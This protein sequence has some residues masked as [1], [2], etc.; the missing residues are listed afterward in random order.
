MKTLCVVM[1]NVCNLRCVM[2]GSQ[3]I[4]DPKPS[5]FISESIWKDL[6]AKLP[7]DYAVEINSVGEHTLHPRFVEF[8]EMLLDRGT[9]V[10]L[11][12]NGM[13]RWDEATTV[14]LIN[15]LSKTHEHC[16]SEIHFSIDGATKK[17]VQEIRLG[18]NF[19]R[20][21]ANI[22]RSIQVSAGRVK[23]GVSYCVNT[24]N[25][26]EM[27]TLLESL[28]GLDC[29]YVNTVVVNRRENYGLSI[30]NRYADFKAYFNSLVTI[31]EHRNVVISS[32]CDPTATNA[33]PGCNFPGYLWMN[34]NGDVSPCCRRYDFVLG[35]IATETLE[36]LL[37]KFDGFDYSHHSC[38]PCFLPT[39]S[40][41][42]RKHF[43]SEE[44]R[45]DFLL[46]HENIKNGWISE[47]EVKFKEALKL[48]AENL[49][50]AMD[51][52]EERNHSPLYTLRVFWK[53]WYRAKKYLGHDPKAVAEIGYGYTRMMGRIYGNMGIPYWGIEPDNRC[54]DNEDTESFLKRWGTAVG[55]NSDTP[56]VSP[57]YGIDISEIPSGFAEYLFSHAVLE[58]IT[59][60]IQDV[61]ASIYRI[62]IPGGIVVHEVDMT[63]H[64]NGRAGESPD[65]FLTFSDKEWE[66]IK[67]SYLSGTILRNRQSD[68]ERIFQSV[69]FDILES[70]TRDV[71]GLKDGALYIVLRKPV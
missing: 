5:S 44:V 8:V 51:S 9:P 65:L 45:N 42:W 36:S 55:F 40:W 43:E 57:N 30:Y 64:H 2:C 3:H 48:E 37:A 41:T 27:T 39:T 60:G 62:M 56:Y 31:A 32:N 66:D 54:W 47:R 52:G 20:I 24:K 18:A 16:K 53:Y 14:R 46:W 50:K 70:K 26:A 22:K 10:K 21:M 6:V 61:V 67:Y 59:D 33:A 23:I 28:P 17:T 1:S 71:D 25:M 69:G 58:H 29:F 15:I 19:D 11:N 38:V 7:P 4:D 12:T 35:N 49:N 68:Y 63:N 13:W 34:V